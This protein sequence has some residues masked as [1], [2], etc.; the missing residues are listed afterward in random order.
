MERKV[1]GAVAMGRARRIVGGRRTATSKIDPQRP[2]LVGDA[3]RVL[4][5]G[6][7][8]RRRGEVGSGST[9][10]VRSRRR[11]REEKRLEART[12]RMPEWCDR[13]RGEPPA[14]KAQKKG[15]HKAVRGADNRTSKRQA[16]GSDASLLF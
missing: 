9:W 15:G 12:A 10:L 11:R 16:N 7:N 3:H 1:V 5:V 14:T 4:R 2:E 8:E 6:R 13:E